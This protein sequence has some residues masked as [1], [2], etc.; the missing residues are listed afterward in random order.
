MSST[1]SVVVIGG[2]GGLGRAVAEH[3]AGQ[4]ADV[5]LSGRD[6][7][8]AKST[9]AEI[10]EQTGAPVRGIALDLSRPPELKDAPEWSAAIKQ[11]LETMLAKSMRAA[12]AGE[13][14]KCRA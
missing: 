3:Y 10:A 5:V 14:E 7:D 6:P 13:A 1:G 8:R 12:I 2:T 9:A 4:G 11:R